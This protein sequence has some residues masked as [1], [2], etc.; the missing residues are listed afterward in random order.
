MTDEAA[1]KGAQ[2][3]DEIKHR[4]SDIESRHGVQSGH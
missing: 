1:P 4:L 3:W 2:H